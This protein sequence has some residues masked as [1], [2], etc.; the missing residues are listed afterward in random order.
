[1]DLQDLLQRF[2]FDNISKIAFGIDPACL[3][4]TLPVSEFSQAFDVA[5]ELSARRATAPISS[6]WKIKRMLNVGSERRLRRAVEVVHHFAM[7]V[8]RQR[9]RETANSAPCKE[10]LLSRFMELANLQ[11]NLPERDAYRSEEF[12]RDSIISFVL[13]GRDT[14]SA[15]LTWFF[16]L[17]SSHPHVAEAIRIEIA[18]LIAAKPEAKRHGNPFVFSYEDLQNMHYLH[19]SIS[20]SMRL[21]PPVPLDS[22]HALHNDVL[23]DG[24][25]VGKGT[26]VT[27][28]PYA[29]GRMDAIWGTD[30]LQFKPERWV[31]EDGHFVPQSTFKFAVFQGGARVCVGK[32]MAFIQMKYVAAAVVSRFRFRRPVDCPSVGDPKLIHSLTAR[33]KGGFPVL[34][35]K[36]EAVTNP[37]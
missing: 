16:W 14:T 15:A 9:R 21:Y 17:L 5:T 36:K 26:R 33:M 7:D 8:I 13:A 20:E 19:A 12:L 18:R 29:M 10:D 6:V 32:D 27:Y 31:N 34:V 2:A 24:T 30:C 35:E 28:H 37:Q 25:F 3:D 23:P 1:L 11:A 4:A 22:K